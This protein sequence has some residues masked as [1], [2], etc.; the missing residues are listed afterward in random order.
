M[1]DVGVGFEEL[2]GVLAR[3]APDGGLV[4]DEE[5]HGVIG[6]HG[7]VDPQVDL[8]LLEEQGVYDVLLGDVL[9]LGDAALLAVAIELPEPFGDLLGHDVDG[10]AG[11]GVALDDVLEPVGFD[12]GLVVFGVDDLE[13]VEA[14]LL[15][16]EPRVRV[17]GCLLVGLLLVGDLGHALLGLVEPLH[18]AEV[19]VVVRRQLGL[20]SQLRDALEVHLLRE[21]AVP[22]LLLVVLLDVEHHEL[23]IAANPPT[24]D[25]S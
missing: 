15:V 9:V 17:G 8:V 21:Q 24:G 10:L 12:P 7:D 25:R 23:Q 11:V 5:L 18:L 6:R 16:V 1:A 19:L 2:G 20:V 4:E 22:R 14:L 3:T 13:E